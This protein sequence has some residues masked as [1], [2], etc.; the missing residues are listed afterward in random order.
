MV[1]RLT[2]SITA[3]S[4][5]MHYYFCLYALLLLSTYRL[6]PIFLN[7]PRGGFLWFTFVS[8]SNLTFK[9][10]EADPV[11]VQERK[12]RSLICVCRPLSG[13]AIAVAVAVEVAVAIVIANA[14]AFFVFG[15][16]KRK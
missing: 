15:K 8:Q 4:V 6:A 11:A 1:Y 12:G 9:S 14:T 3:T 2:W 13:T 10:F 5:Y 7:I 16:K